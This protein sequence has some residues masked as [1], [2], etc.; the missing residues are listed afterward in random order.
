MSGTNLDLQN[1]SIQWEQV[2]VISSPGNLSYAWAWTLPGGQRSGLTILCS[3]VTGSSNPPSLG[4]RRTRSAIGNPQ[5]AIN[6]SPSQGL[7]TIRNS[8]S[9]IRNAGLLMEKYNHT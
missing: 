2:F 4:L 9:T 6:S 8:Q 5:S 1:G 3:E 7:R